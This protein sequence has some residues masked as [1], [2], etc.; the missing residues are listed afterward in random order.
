[1]T[2]SALRILLVEDNP[3]DAR[4]V[5]ELL[6][7]ANRHSVDLVC[8]GDLA[9]ARAQL[10]AHSFDVVLLDLSLP[11]SRGLDTLAAVRAQAP[12]TATVILTGLDD[13]ATAVRALGAGA[14]DYLVKAQMQGPLLV[15][16]LRYAVERQRNEDEIRRFAADLERRVEERTAALATANQELEAFAY[17]VSHDL[18]APLRH[19]DGFAQLLRK[20]CAGQLDEQAAHYV[21]AITK[22]AA[23]MGLLIDDLL[24]FS[25]TGR[26]EMQLHRVDLARLV[27]E[28]QQDLDATLLPRRVMW[29]IGSLPAVEADAGLLRVVLMNLLSNA[30]KFTAPRAA[31]RIEVVAAPKPPPR[32]SPLGEKVPLL[33]TK[34]GSGEVGTG[35]ATRPPPAPSLASDV[36]PSAIRHPPSDQ[37]VIAV[38]DN[39]VGFDMQ[40]VDKL[41]GVF[42]RLHQ[43]DQFE[44]TGIGLATVRRIIHRHGGEVWAEGAVDQGAT[45]Y[46]SLK[47]AKEREG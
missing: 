41:F 15:R 10:A 37:V 6:R 34:E 46:F 24:Q 8:A 18:R 22:S 23:T 19:L 31:A 2:N 16:A 43:E 42:Q 45:F 39:G 32:H 30:I 28:V 12:N 27:T 38:R 11:D 47:A 33:T 21:D 26:S 4:L 36:A 9:S 14:Q 3:G 29:T 7:D 20:R 5:R 1:M 44:G 35:A 40:Y 13:E 17:S 25:R